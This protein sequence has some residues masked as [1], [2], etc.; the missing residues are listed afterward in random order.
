MENT[1][2]R[3]PQ[4]ET[5]LEEANAGNVTGGEGAME[6]SAGERVPF[7][8]LIENEYRQDYEAAVSQRIQAAIQ[9]R[10]RNHQDYKA[11]WETYQPVLDAL[12]ER[13]GGE[14]VQP[15]EMAARL[16][17]ETARSRTAQA[18]QNA[19]DWA[20]RKHFGELN[21]QAEELKKA[22]P[23]FDLMREISNPAFLRLTAPGSRMSVKDAFYAIHGEEIQRDSMRY[24]AKRAGE[25]IAASVRA[26]ASRPMENGL[27][28]QSA[29]TLGIDIAHMDKK[30]RQQYRQRIRSGEEINFR[31]KI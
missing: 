20:T 14:S 12:K 1:D 7:Q 3:Q 15:V 18:N 27:Q 25:S 6:R 30:T 21:R 13:Y 28:G 23:D 4:A 9:Q 31:D 2:M 19:R 17:A 5:P 8:R 29:V 11:K 10:F 24:A 26:G 16:R 22:F